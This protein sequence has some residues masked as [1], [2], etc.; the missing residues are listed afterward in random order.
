MIWSRCGACVN[1]VM[2]IIWAHL[3]LLQSAGVE[4]RFSSRWRAP[5]SMS[6]RFMALNLLPIPRSTVSYCRGL[7]PNKLS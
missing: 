6:S 1:L 3:R 2:A 4:E 5:E 7:L